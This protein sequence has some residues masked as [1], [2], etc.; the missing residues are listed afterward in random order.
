[1]K[2]LAFQQN[3]WAKDADRA[4]RQVARY[5]HAWTRKF[6]AMYMPKRHSGRRLRATFGDLFDLIV[7]DNVSP[8]IAGKASANPG[9]DLDHVRRMLKEEEPDVVLAFGRSA[10]GALRGLWTGTLICGPH[11]AARQSDTT[12]RLQSMAKELRQL[13]ES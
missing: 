3:P 1:M 13:I 7:W 5:G 4:M 11:P 2:I 9:P 8:I 12:S 10:T 6:I